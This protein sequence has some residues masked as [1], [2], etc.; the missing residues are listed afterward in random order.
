MLDKLE[1]KLT[2]GY[3]ISESEF[4]LLNAHQRF[5]YMLS[6]FYI[7]MD[8]SVLVR[9]S[10]ASFGTIYGFHESGVLIEYMGQ[11]GPRYKN[12]TELPSLDVNLP[13]LNVTVLID[14]ELQSY[15]PL[16][17][18]PDFVKIRNNK[19]ELICE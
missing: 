9:K 12:Y 2:Q 13:K 6:K 16:W 7:G 8:I 4:N 18:Y 11:S 14:G 5:A 19:I 3:H 10:E 1:P 15:Y 17:I